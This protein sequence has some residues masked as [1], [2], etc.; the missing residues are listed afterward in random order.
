MIQRLKLPR[1]N[2]ILIEIYKNSSSNKYSQKLNR[3]IKGS[4]SHLRA[5]MKK[6]EKKNII[7][8]TPHK[9]QKNIELTEKGEKI[10][11]A[12]LTIKTAL[13]ND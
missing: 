11:I 9:N 3:K 4:L 1:W 8:R 13:H 2:E 12:V 6:L 5:I 10:A 7:I